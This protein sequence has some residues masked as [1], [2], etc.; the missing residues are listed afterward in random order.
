MS[1]CVPTPKIFLLIFIP[2]STQQLFIYSLSS[3]LLFSSPLHFLFHSAPIHPTFT[4]QLFVYS[5]SSLLLSSFPLPL[6]NPSSFL[7]L[8][9]SPLHLLFISSLSPLQ[10][11]NNSI[12]HSFTHLPTYFSSVHSIHQVNTYIINYSASP[13]LFAPKQ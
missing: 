10:I 7:H 3:L 11:Y 2:S 5:S 6:S 12:A 1:E 9:S 4:Q 8:S 13:V